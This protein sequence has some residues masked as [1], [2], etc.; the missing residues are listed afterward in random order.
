MSLEGCDLAILQS[1][2]CGDSPESTFF[3]LMLKI[4]VESGLSF[5]ELARFPWARSLGSSNS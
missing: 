4:T 1:S 5:G 3:I 2:K